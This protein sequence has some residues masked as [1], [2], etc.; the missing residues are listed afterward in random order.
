MTLVVVSK[1][2]AYDQENTAFVCF[3]NTTIDRYVTSF[4]T[5]GSHLT[6][7]ATTVDL[8]TELVPIDI[9]QII[10]SI[11][12]YFQKC[13]TLKLAYTVRYTYAE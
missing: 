11:N 3:F 2:A 4:S 6:K 12:K 1:Q 5:A 8:Q 7:I 10:A 13:H 9:K